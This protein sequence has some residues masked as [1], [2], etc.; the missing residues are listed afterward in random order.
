MKLDKIGVIVGIVAGVV[1]IWY[2]LR[3][4]PDSNLVTYPNTQA[5]GQPAGQN[6]STTYNIAAPSPMPSPNLIYGDAPNL[7][8][9]PAYQSFN[10]SPINILGLTPQGAAAVTVPKPPLVAPDHGCCDSGCGCASCAGGGT[11]QDGNQNSCLLANPAEQARAGS[12]AMY[13]KL[14][15][16]INSS[17]VG[18]NGGATV[19][20]LGDSPMPIEDAAGTAPAQRQGIQQGQAGQGGPNAPPLVPPLLT[21]QQFG[22]LVGINSGGA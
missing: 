16:N 12:G 17:S 21:W 3:G 6:A 10:Y 15:N 13:Q 9:T 14:Q 2:Y 5:S 4:T 20:S 22:A 18:P 7:P 1:A 11:Y 8:A 19:T